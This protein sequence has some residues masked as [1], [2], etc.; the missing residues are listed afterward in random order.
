LLDMTLSWTGRRR[1][2]MSVPFWLAKL[3]ATIIRPLPNTIRPVT[4]DEVLLLERPNGVGQVAIREERTLSG[5]GIEHPN[6]METVVPT[7]LQRFHRRGQFAQYR[8]S[9]RSP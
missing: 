7:Y 8:P 2:Y 9:A 6:A 3:T 5:L 1:W 4:I